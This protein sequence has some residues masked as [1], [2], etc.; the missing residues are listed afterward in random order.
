M[1]EINYKDFAKFAKSRGISSMELDNVTSKVVTDNNQYTDVF[2]ELLKENQI[3][4]GDEFNPYTCNV[5][6]AELLY[7]NYVNPDKDITIYIN[8]P[9]GS[10]Y[11]G[12]AV[13]DTINFINNDV[14]MIG[15]GMAASM[16]ATL[17]SSGTKGKR[18]A[19]PHTRIMIHSVSSACEGRFSDFENNYKEFK[20]T[21]D[22]MMSLL[23]ENTG[24]SIEKLDELCKMDYWMTAADAKEFGIIDEVIFNKK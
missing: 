11:D 18:Y 8:S 10:V 22:E 14:S 2:S 1:S 21:Q 20:R 12:M 15:I 3:Y 4:F 16:G 24:Q 5:A 7:L 6:I 19:L 13:I 17:L 23:S 9:G